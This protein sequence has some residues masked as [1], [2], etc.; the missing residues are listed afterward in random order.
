MAKKVKSQV[1]VLKKLGL[2]PMPKNATVA[3][4]EKRKEIL[5]KKI[6]SGKY[7]GHLLHRC[8]SYIWSADYRIRQLTGVGKIRGA[9]KINLNQPMLPNFIKQLDMVRIEEMVAERLYNEMKSTI[10]SGGRRSRR[11]AS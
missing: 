3:D 10:A 2:K 5:R 1:A 11:K 4:Y 7:R 6:A 9:K 8:H